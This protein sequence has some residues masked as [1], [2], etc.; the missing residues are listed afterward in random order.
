MLGVKIMVLQLKGDFQ[1]GVAVRAAGHK[2]AVEIKKAVNDVR[3][4]VE[5]VG[6]KT[7]DRITQSRVRKLEEA[8]SAFTKL[9]TNPKDDS[10]SILQ[11]RLERQFLEIQGLVI[12]QRIAIKA[13]AER[14][15]KGAE[16][17]DEI[18]IL[19]TTLKDLKIDEVVNINF[20]K[21]SEKIAN[22]LPHVTTINSFAE[23]TRIHELTNANLVE[24]GKRFI[25]DAM[26]K[27]ADQLTDSQKIQYF[28]ESVGRGRLSEFYLEYAEP[29]VKA[30]FEPSTELNA[31]IDVKLPALF[32]KFVTTKA[33]VQTFDTLIDDTLESL[34]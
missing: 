21:K 14:H 32:G 26:K 19:L 10:P 1:K 25:I 17:Y 31:L 3:E 28:K 4:A 20:D 29:L 8:S 16:R 30:A 9:A 7:A 11:D 34:K 5:A 13:E 18:L 24:I 33:Q 23:M 27:S 12:D 2:L 6:T 22:E 15:P